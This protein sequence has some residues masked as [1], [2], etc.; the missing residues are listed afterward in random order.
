[1]SFLSAIWN[2]IKGLFV[3]ARPG[4][5]EFL[6]KHTEPV[7]QVI[8]RLALV[9]DGEDFH[10]WKDEVFTVVKDELLA[11]EK[12]IKDNWIQ[13]AIGFAFEEF[14]KFILDTKK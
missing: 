7:F 10:T 5:E 2:F 12:E 6:K 9:H 8:K 1:M 3:K 13:L 14:K 4:L 11:G